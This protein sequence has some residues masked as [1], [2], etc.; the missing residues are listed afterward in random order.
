MNQ[1]QTGLFRLKAIIGDP[2]ANPPIAP[3]IPVSKS[4]W[5]QGVKDGRYPKPVKIGARCTAWRA[6]DI[7]AYINGLGGVNQEQPP[8]NTGNRAQ[9]QRMQKGAPRSAPIKQAGM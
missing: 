8:E 4:S 2:E 9:Q 6:S 1:P 5:W 7:Y 3:L